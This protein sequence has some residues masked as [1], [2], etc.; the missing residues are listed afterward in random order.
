MASLPIRVGGLGLYSALEASLYAFLVSRAQSRVL[1]DHILRHNGV[2]VMD[3][4][5]DRAL[6]SLSIT[7]PDFDLSNFTNKDTFP[8]KA[9]HILASSLFSKVVKHIDVKLDMTMW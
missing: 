5:F 2:Y 3:S 4:N 7:I 9:K 8:P 6:D 1:Q